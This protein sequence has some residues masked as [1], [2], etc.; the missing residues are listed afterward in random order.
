MKFFEKHTI[1]RLFLSVF[2]FALL[3]YT[4]KSIPSWKIQ[5]QVPPDLSKEAK[6]PGKE[7]GQ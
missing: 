1:R 4:V 5:K 6:T 2:I 3:I 7:I